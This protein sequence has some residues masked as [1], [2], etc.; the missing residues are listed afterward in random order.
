MPLNP[1]WKC[2]LF[3]PKAETGIRNPQLALAWWE[4]AEKP[5]VMGVGVSKQ[6]ILARLCNGLPPTTPISLDQWTKPEEG[7]VG[8]LWS[9]KMSL[10]GSGG[11]ELVAQA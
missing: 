5:E 3:I 7:L 10:R 9:I 4:L 8:M 6:Y 2:S 11:K 1:S